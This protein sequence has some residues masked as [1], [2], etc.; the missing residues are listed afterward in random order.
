M[1]HAGERPAEAAGER[2][3][4]FDRVECCQTFH[5]DCF[6]GVTTHNRLVLLLSNV[7]TFD[8]GLTSGTA[9]PIQARWAP[10][11]QPQIGVLSGEHGAPLRHISQINNLCI[12]HY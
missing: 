9:R 11:S 4:R 8:T 2:L 12:S 3:C 5:L 6:Q 7:V 10:G 1:Q